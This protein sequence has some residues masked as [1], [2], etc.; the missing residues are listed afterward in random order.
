MDTIIPS[1]GPNITNQG[2]S[3]V[4]NIPIIQTLNSKLITKPP[5][6]NDV[7][8]TTVSSIQPQI[9]FKQTTNGN[10]RIS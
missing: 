3:Y 9:T 6:K 2:I 5:I 4:A 10:S 1:G 8:S 7:K